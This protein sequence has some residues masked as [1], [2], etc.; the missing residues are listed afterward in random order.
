M[1]RARDSSGDVVEYEYDSGDRLRT[2]RYAGG[3]TTVYSYDAA[4]RIIKV[5]DPA[6]NMTLEIKY[7]ASGNVAAFKTD[8]EH[9]YTFGYMAGNDEKATNVSITDPGGRV[10]R[11]NI[12][13]EGS[14]ISY[15][16]QR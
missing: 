11:V 10:I 1:I 14:R 8:S 3:E 12:Y 9:T 13:N 7:D 4:D 15:V 5:E 16:I 2:V 6:E